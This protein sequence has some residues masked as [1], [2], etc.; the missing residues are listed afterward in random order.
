MSQHM[1]QSA[2][3]AEQG[4]EP[5]TLVAAALLHDIGHYTNEFPEDA[6]EKGTNNFHESAGAQFLS[7]YFPQEIVDCVR[8]HVAAKRYLCA[9]QP[10]YYKRLSDASKHTLRL[11]GGPMTDTEVEKFEK[12]QFLENIIKVRLWDDE[13]KDAQASTPDFSYYRPVLQK[14]VERHHLSR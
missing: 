7:S 5:E 14:I 12:L 3:L 4:Q 10:E 1:L 9:T 11:Q 6:L 13:G 8:Y 2:Q